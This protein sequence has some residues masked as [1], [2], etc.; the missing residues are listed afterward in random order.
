[1]HQKSKTNDLNFDFSKTFWGGAH[2]APPHSPHNFQVL[3]S[4]LINDIYVY[5]GPSTRS[6]LS[7]QLW[8]GELGLPLPL[9]KKNPGSASAMQS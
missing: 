8:I 2:Q 1:M 5:F 4:A 7:P 9:L 6:V 3:R